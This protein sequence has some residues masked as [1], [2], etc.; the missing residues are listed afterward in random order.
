[1][2]RPLSIR[3]PPGSAARD[4]GNAAVS[5]LFRPGNQR[6]EMKI[7][8]SKTSTNPNPIEQKC[9]KVSLTVIGC[10]GSSLSA[11]VCVKIL[12]LFWKHPLCAWSSLVMSKF[13][14]CEYCLDQLNNNKK[15]RFR[16]MNYKQWKRK[17][18]DSKVD[19]VRLNVSWYYSQK[20]LQKHH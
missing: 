11:M 18:I 6:R 1:L 20:A 19:Q 15:L 8:V 12:L 16:D 3:L 9:Y 13:D 10:S 5:G 2:L 4:W 14:C 7:A 17:V